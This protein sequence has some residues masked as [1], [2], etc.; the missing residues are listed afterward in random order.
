VT[1]RNVV[2]AV[3]ILGLGSVIGF[4]LFAAGWLCRDREARTQQ[5]ELVRKANAA[6]DAIA[7]E[8]ALA[9]EPQDFELWAKELR[10]R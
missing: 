8:V 3:L 5:A 6:L 1:A 7:A 9:Y 4:A 2:D 10:D